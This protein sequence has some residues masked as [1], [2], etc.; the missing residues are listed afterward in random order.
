MKFFY[1]LLLIGPTFLS[2][3]EDLLSLIAEEPK[4]N[5]KVYA[6]FKTFRLGNAQTIETVKK[7]HLDF[8]IAHRFGNIY[9]SDLANPINETFQSFFGFDN[10]KDI[11]FSFDYG[12]TDDI[13][14]GI[15]RSAMGKLFDGSLKWKLLK[16]T[17]NFKVPVSITF[18]GDLGY[19]FAPTSVI[20]GGINKNF[21]TN[22]L[23][24]F[25]YISQFIIASKLHKSISLEILPTYVHRNFIT[26]RIN[27]NNDAEDV[28]GF[29]SLGFGGRV[30]LTKRVCLIGDYFY[31]F[32]GFYKNNDAV[33]MPLSFGVELETGGHV[34]SLFFT[35]AGGLIENNF[36]P[37]TF[38]S[39]NKGQVKFGF[40]ISRTFA[41]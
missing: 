36:I 26:Q 34:F 33:K 30:K 9:N 2:A 8:R 38:D 3:Q 16:Q 7:N 32:A 39:W 29:F 10:N 37:N 6:T 41:L 1:T 14:I 28:N 19:T 13:T 18:F 17:T 40:N 23:H 27:T 12:V 4:K 22:E 20:Y 15:G 25:N 24:R 31:N 35:N 11:R 21:E 5:E